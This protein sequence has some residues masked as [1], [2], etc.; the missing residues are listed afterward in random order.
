MHTRTLGFLGGGNMAGAL[1][2]GLLHA[3]VLGPERILVSDVKRERLEHLRETHKIVINTDN[4]ELVKRVDV[5]VLAV[6]PHAADRGC[7][8]IGKDVGKYTLVISVAAGVPIAAM[9][10]R[11]PEG[12]KV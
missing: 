11:L 8:P 10:A 4:H 1:I 5:P 9:E 7:A 12:A 2:K 6:N 3:K